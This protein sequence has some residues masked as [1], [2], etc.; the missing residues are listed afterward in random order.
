[1]TDYSNDPNYE[2]EE[3]GVYRDLTTNEVVFVLDEE[4]GE[5]LAKILERDTDRENEYTLT[6]DE[7]N[8]LFKLGDNDKVS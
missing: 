2:L 7:F 8:K 1:M 6:S 4:T 5:S 3:E